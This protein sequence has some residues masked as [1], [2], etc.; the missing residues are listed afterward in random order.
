MAL[1]SAWS[2]E[3]CMA[4][5]VTTME[6]YGGRGHMVRQETRERLGGA[7]IFYNNPLSR[8]NQDPMRTT[9]IF[10]E[11]VPQMTY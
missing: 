8:T 7:L 4:D 1:A 9:L 6:A 11:V 2:G 5:G 3:D 10:S